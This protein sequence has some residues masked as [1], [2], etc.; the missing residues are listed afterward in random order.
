M[1]N[2]TSVVVAILGIVWLA[3]IPTM[4][5][6]IGVSIFLLGAF[7]YFHPLETDAPM[8]GLLV[9]GV[10]V[11]TN[12]ISSLLGREINRRRTMDPMIVTL[13]SMG[14]GSITLLVPGVLLQGLPSMNLL[15]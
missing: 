15:S 1:L 10:V 12:A 7:I 4:L 9:G 2:F 8:L 13:V 14:V 6:W 3:E 5:Q 11:V